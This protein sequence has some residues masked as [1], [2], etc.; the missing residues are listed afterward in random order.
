[1]VRTLSDT[2]ESKVGD[3]ILSR[4]ID[5]IEGRNR[6][7]IYGEKPEKEI[8]A[9]NIEPN[10][11][12]SNNNSISIRFI[13]DENH[14]DIEISISFRIYRPSK[15]SYSAYEH[16]DQNIDY[17]NTESDVHPLSRGY[18]VPEDF[19]YK[20]HV[21]FQKLN[22]CINDI[23][24]QINKDLNQLFHDKD[25]YNY[26][27]FNKSIDKLKHL[28]KEQYQSY[29]NELEKIDD[30]S[31]TSISVDLVEG[32][33]DNE[34]QITLT[35][36]SNVEYAKSRNH[37]FNPKI[38]VKGSFNS[39]EYNG[40]SPQD[41]KYDDQVPAIGHNVSVDHT[42]NE[43]KEIIETT[44]IPEEE[45]HEFK[46]EKQ[47]KNNV[48]FQSLSSDDLLT[49]LKEVQNGMS[50]YIE[51]WENMRFA[52]DQIDEKAQV[53]Y[54]K[55][56]EKFKNEYQRFSIGVRLLE[57]NP[58]LLK[59]F[60]YMNDTFFRTFAE[61]REDG[62]EFWRLFQIVF[63]VSNIWRM[64]EREVDIDKTEEMEESAEV[65]WFP[66]GGGKTEAYIGLIILNLFYD[67]L[68]GKER[69]VTSWIRYPRRLLSQQ[70]VDRFLEVIMMANRV[71]SDTGLTG[72]KFSLGT[73]MG[74]RDTPN[75]LEKVS[76]EFI[77]KIQ[78]RN[79]V[80]ARDKVVKSWMIIYDCPLCSNEL[81][82]SLENETITFECDKCGKIPI[83]TTDQEIYRYTPSVLIGTLDK[84]THIHWTPKF[85][86]IL[87]NTTCEC[88]DHGFGYMGECISE[89]C[90]KQS[91]KTIDDFYDPI[92]TLHM[93][94]EV[95]MLEEELG[96]FSSHYETTYLQ[97]CELIDHKKPHV[98]TST[99]TIS[100]ASEH[101]NN[102]FDMNAIRFPE[103]GPKQGE[104]FYGRKIHKTARKYLGLNPRT[105]SYLDASLEVCRRYLQNI[106]DL[107]TK[108]K[109]N[110]IPKN[111]DQI[112]KDNIIDILNLYEVSIAYFLER[113]EKDK[114]INSVQRQ[115]KEEVQGAG[116]NYEPSAEQLSSDVDNPNIEKFEN[117]SSDPDKSF[118]NRVDTIAATSFISHGIDVDAF[119]FM[120][121]A[122]QPE[123]KFEYI[124]SSSRV[125]RDDDV[126]G[127][128][129]NIF[130]TY[131]QRD[132]IRYKYFNIRHRNL[133]RNIKPV[134][135]DR[136]SKHAIK[137]TYPGI[138][139]SVFYQY[140][141][142][143]YYRENNQR[144]TTHA[145]LS[146]AI[147][148]NIVNKDDITQH[149]FDCYQ[150]DSSE[151]SDYKQFLNARIEKTWKRL[152]NEDYKHG[153]DIVDNDP[154][155]SLRNIGDEI[156]F[157]IISSHN[158]F[159]EVIENE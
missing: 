152:D 155:I 107:R 66:T 109:N 49:N 60:K 77:D 36:V 73:F 15:P 151:K 51:D 140:I 48:T 102:L 13:N 53:E 148:S 62:F 32:N 159:K 150:A 54:K 40:M 22:E 121:F 6:N 128:V 81:S 99:A 14:G 18:Y 92:P 91:R 139:N 132:T 72:E 68:R 43:S 104:I 88:P 74:G 26:R 84:I 126:P 12:D 111:L 149:I 147:D 131:Y 133:D 11:E 2:T 122:E 42:E 41:Y 21:E 39:Y 80:R 87:G 85:S 47:F 97:V 157:N 113:R 100:N 71:K 58:D 50:E 145:G 94:D 135:I 93:I 57:D 114:Y 146:D 45:V 115:M 3:H 64:A 67:R 23:Q 105:L 116:Y 33:R 95:H 24:T 52:E 78:S 59:S 153:M 16:I 138:F 82:V 9:S 31:K 112:D 29:V 44:F 46:F 123:E 156:D 56:L 63:I 65:L 83:K 137:K 79:N 86:N 129:L 124:Q 38:T 143:K 136:W 76:D 144:A 10:S 90:D 7:Y 120:V 117:L 127:Y 25:F 101:M 55:N 35:N 141:Y 5:D 30:I 20:R 134:S 8:F 125:G 96:A 142:P 17:K 119:N 28:K 75:R 19:S 37:V 158:K 27:Y 34:R 4:L 106:I 70:Q 154:M 61:E 1:M 69:G 103:E 110:N 98:V 108:I 118:N 89:N 130:D